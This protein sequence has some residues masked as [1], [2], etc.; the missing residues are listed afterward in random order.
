MKKSLGLLCLIMFFLTACTQPAEPSVPTKEPK[1]QANLETIPDKKPPTWEEKYNLGLRYL[2][3]EKYEEAIIAFTSAIEINPK[4]ALAYIGRGNA[5]VGLGTTTD[6][7]TAAKADYTEA[8]SLDET[9][10]DAYLGLANV[11]IIL[12]EYE[13]VKTLLQDADKWIPSEETEKILSSLP[14]DTS[15]PENQESEDTNIYHSYFDNPLSYEEIRTAVLSQ[16]IDLTSEMYEGYVGGYVEVEPLFRNMYI[17]MSKS[18]AMN[19]LGFTKQGIRYAEE[20]QCSGYL[21]QDGLCDCAWNASG[22]IEPHNFEFYFFYCTDIGAEIR[23]EFE[24]ETLVQVIL[25]GFL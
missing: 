8:I 6:N 3:E 20:Q 12:E 23:F 16:G 17:G 1:L 14:I 2:R 13:A 4:K 9:N 18:E 25:Y 7:L 10:T 24:M 19:A 5:Y 21:I 15:G 22:G 11:Y